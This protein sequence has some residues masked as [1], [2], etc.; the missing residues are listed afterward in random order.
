[1]HALEVDVA[2]SQADVVRAIADQAS[3]RHGLVLEYV[4]EF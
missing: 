4:D 2:S 1:V 3:A